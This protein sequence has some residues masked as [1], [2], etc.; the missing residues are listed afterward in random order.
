MR[1]PSNSTQLIRL[2]RERDALKRTVRTLTIE[3]QGYALRAKVSECL[4]MD[5]RKELAKVTNRLDT[6]M[7]TP[8]LPGAIHIHAFGD[9]TR[10]TPGGFYSRCECGA[11]L[12]EPGVITREQVPTSTDGLGNPFPSARESS[13]KDA[14]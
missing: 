12:W 5:F 10:P 4:L 6:L 13:G 11:E 7:P 1:K 9:S 8:P 14:P 2:R 3:R